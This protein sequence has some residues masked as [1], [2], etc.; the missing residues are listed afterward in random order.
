MD[1]SKNEELFLRSLDGSISDIDSANLINSIA[2]SKD[3][4]HRSK[5]LLQVREML[6]NKE[7]QTFGPFF[8]ERVAYRISQLKKEVD[9]QIFYFFKKYQLLAAGVVVALL[10][11]NM[12]VSDQLS[13]KSIL[14][15]EEE[16]IQE[17]LAIDVYS[18]LTK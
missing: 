7:P 9:Y 10:A 3:L 18:V 14:G 5:Q 17:V 8:A 11:I 13:V 12:L 16:A 15:F 1:V 2:Q 4:A 6:A